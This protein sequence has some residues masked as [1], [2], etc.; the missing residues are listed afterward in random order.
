[1]FSLKNKVTVITGGGSGIGKSTAQRFAKAGAKV[2]I[3]DLQDA[4]ELA[5]DISCI[6]VKT[7]VAIETQVEALMETAVKEYGA[8]DVVVNNAGIGVGAEIKD[9]KEDDFDRTIMVNTKGVLW[10]IKHA[11]PRISNGGCILNTAS[12]AAMV[13][14]PS[15]GAYSASKAA[16]VS[17]TQIAALELAPR[18]IRVNSVCPNAIQ[19]PMIEESEDAEVEVALAPYFTPLGRMGQPEEVAALLHFLASDE[20]SFLT[21]MA[22]PVDGGLQAGIGLGLIEPLL[23][24]IRNQ[25]AE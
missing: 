14:F 17:L 6:F 18:K 3:G 9:I 7:D 10:G 24:M 25:A 8:L 1:M 13:G 20:A 4:T 2:V 5:R 23:E 15:Y 19:T 12:M 16:V 22:I 21:G 11:T